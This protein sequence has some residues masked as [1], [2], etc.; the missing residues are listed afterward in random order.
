MYKEKMTG[1][2]HVKN[3]EAELPQPSS[4]LDLPSVGSAAVRSYQLLSPLG[5][6]APIIGSQSARK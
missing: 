2:A 1:E 6:L 4:C 3:I 5:C